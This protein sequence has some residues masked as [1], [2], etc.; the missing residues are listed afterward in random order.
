MLDEVIY[1]ERY[2]VLVLY[3]VSS[4]NGVLSTHIDIT[5]IVMLLYFYIVLLLLMIKKYFG[6]QTSISA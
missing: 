2:W 4:V 5:I 1:F 3:V 6:A